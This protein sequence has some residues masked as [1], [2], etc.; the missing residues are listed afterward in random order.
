MLLIISLGTKDHTGQLIVTLDG[1]G[2]QLRF[3]FFW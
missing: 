2:V 1:I 3:I